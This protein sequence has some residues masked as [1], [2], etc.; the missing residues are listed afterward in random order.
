[1]FFDEITYKKDFH[2]QLKNIYDLYNAKVF[3]SSSSASGLKDQ[4]AYLTGRHRITEI[5]PL[6]FDE[7]LSFRKI[8]IKKADK[9]L[10]KAYFEE[11]ME[12]GGIPEYV[13]TQEIEYLKQLVD[14]IIY[15]DIIAMHNIREKIQ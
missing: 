11:Y 14:D 5:L 6:D 1:L 13:L 8:T 12:I 3:V 4:K 9:H 7:F 10:L 15:K 2:V